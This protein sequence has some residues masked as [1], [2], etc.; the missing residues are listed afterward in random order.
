[1]PSAA[2][3]PAAGQSQ[4]P[5]DLACSLHAT[6]LLSQAGSPKRAR[7]SCE[8]SVCACECVCVCK[9]VH[10][11]EPAA[12]A[13]IAAPRTQARAQVAQLGLLA[14]REGHRA[15]IEALQA[16][17]PCD[18][19]PQHGSAQAEWQ[20]SASGQ[21]GCP[22]AGQWPIDPHRVLCIPLVAQHLMRVCLWEALL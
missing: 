4:L 11:A 12:A 3:S 5:L 21:Q 6:W 14:L 15:A 17:H 16:S 9:C 20:L 19:L 8:S 1:M 18:H 7:P 2:I 13:S 22:Q 10:A